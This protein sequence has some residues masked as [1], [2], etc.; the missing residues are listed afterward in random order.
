[1]SVRY[2]ITCQSDTCQVHVYPSQVH[3]SQVHASQIYAS[4]IPSTSPILYKMA[5]QEEQQKAQS[6]TSKMA[7][8]C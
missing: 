8:K 5:E 1:M 6:I 3:A 2:I 4:Q 7:E